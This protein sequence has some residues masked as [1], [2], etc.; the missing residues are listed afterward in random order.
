MISA[1]VLP[2]TVLCALLGAASA[3]AQTAAPQPSPWPQTPT[4]TAPAQMAPAAPVAQPVQPAPAQQAAP[5][6]QTPPCFNE[7]LPLRQEAE[8]RAE[9]LRTAGQPG[10]AKLTQPEACKAFKE[11]AAAEGKMM[12]FVEEK[13]VWCGIPLEAVKQMKANHLRTV[14]MRDQVCNAARPAAAAPAAPSLSDAL[15]TA[16]IP[17]ARNTNTGRGTLDTLTGN[18]IAR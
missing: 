13:N 3:G 18:P 10:K 1:R 12:K 14:K 2:V 8:K 7:F 15:G 9:P 5:Q 6:G 16:R 11:F 4:Q 17:D